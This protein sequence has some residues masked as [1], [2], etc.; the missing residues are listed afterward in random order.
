MERIITGN[1]FA[2]L[3]GLERQSFHIEND[4]HSSILVE[5]DL[6]RKPVSTF[7]DHALT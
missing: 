2:G 4:W 6:F 5:H 1:F 7:Q 3:A